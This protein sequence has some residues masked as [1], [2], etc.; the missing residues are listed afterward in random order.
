MEIQPCVAADLLQGGQCCGAIL[1]DIFGRP[2]HPDK[3][4]EGGLKV[5]LQLVR[6][7]LQDMQKEGC[8]Q[9]ECYTMT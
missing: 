2:D 3:L 9:A 6:M 4:L 5:Y 7:P 1:H 8:M